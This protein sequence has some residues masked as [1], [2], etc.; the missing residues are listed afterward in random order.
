MQEA[1]EMFHSVE[2]DRGTILRDVL[3]G[4]VHN[5]EENASMPPKISGRFNR[6]EV[7]QIELN[8]SQIDAM[9]S[10]MSR[11]LTI[12]QGPPGTGKTHTAVATLAQLAREG[13][14]PILATAESN[15]AVDNL[16]EGLLGLGVRAVRIGR[17]VKV[18]ETLRMATL[19][20]QLEEH[21]KQDEIAIVR[22]EMDEVHRA[23]PKLKG[24]EKGLAHRDIQHNKKELRR[25]EREMIASVLDSAEVICST[26]IGSGHRILDG[27][28]FPIVLM[29]EATQAIEPSALIPIS[30]GCR[31]LVLVGDHRQLP[32]TV[33][34]KKAEHGG[35]GRSLF[36]RLIDVGIQ[37]NLL[38]VQYRM[39]PV[40][41]EYP[42]ARF[43]DDRLKDGC[44]ASE[45]PSPA[46]ILW[47]DWDHPFAFIPISGV[48]DEE[49]E[50]GSRSNPIEAARIYDLVQ[51]LLL[52]G[53]VHPSEIGIITPYSGQVRALSDIF[54]SN[55]G[56]EEGGQFA[57][58]EINSVDGYQ[59]RE[60]DV[61]IFSAVRSNPDGVVGFLS[62]QRRLNVAITRAKRGLIVVGD[63]QTLRYDPTWRS[64]LD[65]AE[66][67]GLFAWHLV[68]G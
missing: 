26:N 55:K 4:Q 54:D 19:D 49:Q 18:R 12:I 41:R 42:S 17:P 10:A 22:D 32:P 3:L 23:L 16:L 30:K 35:L 39:H 62:D 36:E 13:R 7:V 15:V 20:A 6:S 59:G 2:G 14:G 40:L 25:L 33:I 1:L 52:P 50:G 27:R 51:G 5:P 61:I 46:G 68:N 43:Y 21:P 44:S 37:T 58:L 47:P 53:D 67:R 24:R 28:R 34:S 65:W 31:Q 60:K 11:R 38:D 64:W 66:E 56:R 29:D 45:R 48:E 8:P 9:N 57:G 63:P